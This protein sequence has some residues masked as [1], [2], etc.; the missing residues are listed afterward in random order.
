MLLLFDG[1]SPAGLVFFFLFFFQGMEEECIFG[2]AEQ[3]A[4]NTPLA[5]QVDP[6]EFI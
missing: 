1:S 6:E 2:L 5:T 3:E 4:S